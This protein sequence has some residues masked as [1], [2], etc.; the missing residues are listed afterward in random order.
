MEKDHS[1]SVIAAATVVMAV[2]ALVNIIVSTY[3]WQATRDATEISRNAF[4]AMQ[5]PL[6]A[7]SKVDTEWDDKKKYLSIAV[8]YKN[9]GSIPAHEVKHT[10]QLLVNGQPLPTQV[11]PGDGTFV[12]VPQVPV[13]LLG[14]IDEPMYSPVRE[15]TSPLA[16]RVEIHYK[17]LSGKTYSFSEHQRWDPYHRRWALVENHID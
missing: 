12:L 14:H 3:Q 13:Q 4:E 6:I 11:H 16:L 1:N 9:F 15:G 5:R 17:G 2:T 8:E 10:W 7:V